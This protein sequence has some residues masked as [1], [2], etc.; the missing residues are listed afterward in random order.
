MLRK[1]E[2]IKKNILLSY[3]P[4]SF[5]LQSFSC[6]FQVAPSIPSSVESAKSQDNNELLQPVSTYQF[7]L[8]LY[9]IRDALDRDFMIY[10]KFQEILI[11]DFRFQ[12]IYPSEYL[13]YHL[14]LCVIYL[15]R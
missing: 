8:T 1:P 13:V 6:S 14:L 11:Q 5:F 10:K 7:C 2:A 4:S 9:F 12:Q 15:L 3:F